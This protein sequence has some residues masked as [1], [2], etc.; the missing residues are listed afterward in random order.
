MQ[1]A[2]QS[3]GHSSWGPKLERTRIVP[4]HRLLYSTSEGLS[5]QPLKIQ[6]ELC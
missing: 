2:E 4:Y 5:L 6:M 1:A 3:H